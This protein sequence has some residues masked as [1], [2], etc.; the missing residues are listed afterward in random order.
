MEPVAR[1]VYR[2]TP[3]VASPADLARF[4]GTNERISVEGY[5][6][7]ITFYE[8]LIQGVTGANQD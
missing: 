3:L 2:F 1:Q 7:M 4:H 5:R 6:D 8:R